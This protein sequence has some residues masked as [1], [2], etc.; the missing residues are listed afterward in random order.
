[1]KGISVCVN[2]GE[3]GIG[4]DWGSWGRTSLCIRTIPK[5]YSRSHFVFAAFALV[6]LWSYRM[7]WFPLV[8]SPPSPV[9]PVS[10]RL[11]TQSRLT[12]FR[13]L[14]G[15]TRR[16]PDWDLPKIPGGRIT[17]FEIL[18]G[19]AWCL[20]V[21]HASCLVNAAFASSPRR[22]SALKR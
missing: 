12:F 2:R 22:D 19:F 6:W 17:E 5:I 10:P 1:M 9:S 14:L 13:C 11:V 21:E 20:R 18:V 3:G 8:P 16:Q 15:Q 7:L 4:G